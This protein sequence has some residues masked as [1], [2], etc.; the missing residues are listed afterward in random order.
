[1]TVKLVIPPK[2]YLSATN[3]TKRAKYRFGTLEMPANK[4]N[5]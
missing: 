4:I 5:K 3:C 1:M 2:M